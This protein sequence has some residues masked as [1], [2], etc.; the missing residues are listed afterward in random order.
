MTFRKCAKNKSKL[1]LSNLRLRRSEKNKS[2]LKFETF[3]KESLFN[4]PEASKQLSL[5]LPSFCK[6]TKNPFKGLLKVKLNWIEFESDVLWML[7]LFVVYENTLQ[8]LR[9]LEDDDCINV[10][11]SSSWNDCLSLN[12]FSTKHHPWHPWCCLWFLECFGKLNLMFSD[13]NMLART[14]RNIHSTL[15]EAVQDGQALIIIIHTIIIIHS[16]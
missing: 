12:S 13:V 11:S 6:R 14:V 15:V 4:F 1:K 10:S 5:V 7:L 8:D 16:F 9:R 2:K 3:Q